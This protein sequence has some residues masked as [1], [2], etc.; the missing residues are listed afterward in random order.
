MRAM[1]HPLLKA[2]NLEESLY[3]ASR[4]KEHGC[5]PVLPQHGVAERYDLLF[6]RPS[7]SPRGPLELPH[8]T[9]V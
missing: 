6:V 3:D 4:A 2:G 7:S 9:A 1:R 5:L 8:G